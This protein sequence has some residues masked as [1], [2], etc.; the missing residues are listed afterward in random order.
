MKTLSAAVSS[1]F[2][3]QHVESRCNKYHH[4]AQFSAHRST[5]ASQ[6]NPPVCSL[7]KYGFC[8]VNVPPGYGGVASWAYTFRLENATCVIKA[9]TGWKSSKQQSILTL[10]PCSSASTAVKL[11][12]RRAHCAEQDELDSSIQPRHFSSLQKRWPQSVVKA[13]PW[14]S[15]QQ[16]L[17]FMA[18]AFCYRLDE[19]APNSGGSRQKNGLPRRPTS[20]QP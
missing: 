7:R 1:A 16:A 13:F 8:A 20:S 12:T 15:C 11:P 18:G 14:I 2:V 10:E 4:A 9:W 19:D 6:R 5:H 17:H 3:S